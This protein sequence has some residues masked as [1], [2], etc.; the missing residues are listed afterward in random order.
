MLGIAIR[1]MRERP[2]RVAATFVALWCGAVIVTVGGVLV[3]SGLRHTVPP[4]RYAAAD[5]VVARQEI[6]FRQN[7][8]DAY[9]ESEFL[10]ERGRLDRSLADDLAAVN[11]VA[12]VV[13]DVSIPVEPV[14]GA[15]H[16]TIVTAAPVLGHGWSSAALAPYALERGVP[17]A[18]DGEVVLDLPTARATGTP[19]GGT[20]TL[21]LTEDLRQYRVSGI[22]GCGCPAPRQ[23]ALF[24]TD[25]QA[26]SLTD[27]QAVRGAG[28]PGTAHAFGLR[29]VPGAD[30]ASVLRGLEKVADGA[31]ARVYTG[32]DRGLAEQFDEAGTRENVIALGG[33]FGGYA[34]LTAV[35]AVC[36]TIGLSVQQRRRDLALLRAVA[37]TPRQVR[38]LVVGEAVAVSLLACAL[39]IPAGWAVTGW[40]RDRLVDRGIVQESFGV[41]LG[42]L[43][44]LATTGTL[45]LVAATAGWFASRGSAR[46]RPTEALEQ[47][48]VEP[49]RIGRAR[50]LTGLVALA[51]GLGLS[52]V[53]RTVGGEAAIGAALGMLF[54]LLLAVSL[55]APWVNRALAAVLRVPFETL[56][57]APGHLAAANLRANAR[58]T[59]SVLTSLVLA[60]G[61]G[62][63][64]WFVQSSLE[65]ETRA[66]HREG[67]LADRAVLADGG[68]PPGLALRAR[69][70]PGVVAAT[71]V[72]TSTAVVQ[73]SDGLETWPI[74]AVDPEGVTGTLDL[75]VRRGS[76]DGLRG[77]TVAVSRVAADHL[78]WEPGERVGLILGDGTAVD[79]TVV[80]VYDR[81]LGFADLTV[82]R[83]VM[84]G[85]TTSGRDGAVLVRTRPGAGARAVDGLTSLL[86]EYPGS[87]LVDADV[88]DG[89]LA[90]EVAVN[91]WINR[92]IVGVLVAY[93][94]ITA[95]NTLLTW[96]LSRR[97]EL[98]VLRL[99]GVTRGQ[100]LRMLR[101][102]QAGMLGGALLLGGTIAGFTLVS[103]V[104]GVTG[105]NV[106]Y[107]PPSG[108]VAVLGGTV[109]LALSSTL[110][111]ARAVL[112]SQ[113]VEGI[114]LRE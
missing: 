26:A 81:G 42:V 41:R 77:P 14:D 62:G 94:A 46:I 6:R 45:V 109:L 7:P 39:G 107:V 49:G 21:R 54:T 22:V 106:A 83:Q 52:L 8:D 103:V 98:S 113:P 34:A 96:T 78:G 88:L 51:G 31:G 60:V 112:R 33:T 71:G 27:A 99:S 19:V 63:S 15:R 48:S 35:F 86:R 43:P 55:L 57:A 92:M 84:A 85:H 5:A 17:P 66:Q 64:L 61:F 3:E 29:L 91:A 47:S 2:G 1:M 24:F 111:P 13:A 12:S 100:V 67:T 80:C 32:S 95:V 82:P 101:W 73:R 93:T 75:G 40:F 70:V 110:L 58:R 53:A 28:H 38:R 36:G 4:Q 79:L 72:S 89:R 9:E 37:A 25:A 76:L 30:S 16:S 74:Q 44:A 97:R 50:A 68:L 56:G 23:Q 104:A 87:T 108:W 114:G 65:R 102:E 11:G 20:V 10:A 90:Q 59:A 69:Q 18:D 105:A